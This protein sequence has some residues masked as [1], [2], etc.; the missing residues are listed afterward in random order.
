MKRLI[1]FRPTYHVATVL[2]RFIVSTRLS[3]SVVVFQAWAEE[4]AVEDADEDAVAADGSNPAAVADAL[5]AV[6]DVVAVEA[7]TE[8]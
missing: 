5:A 3:A 1:S 7:V 4:V 2:Y 6:E 8:V